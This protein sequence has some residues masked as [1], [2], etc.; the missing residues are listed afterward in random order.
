LSIL[1][2]VPQAGDPGGVTLNLLHRYSAMSHAD[3]AGHRG[4]A[5]AGDEQRRAAAK[6]CS[7]CS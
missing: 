4:G 5:G 6:G 2:S 1:T 7:S 3:L